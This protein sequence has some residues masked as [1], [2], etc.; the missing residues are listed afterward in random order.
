LIAGKA[1]GENPCLLRADSQTVA[2]AISIS[3]SER[4]NLF[5]A[6]DQY[7]SGILAGDW[8]AL[9]GQWSPLFQH[10]ISQD[11]F[12]KHMVSSK[13]DVTEY[14]VK[15]YVVE[16]N[17]ARLVVRIGDSEG[18]PRYGIALWG[19][20]QEGRWRCIDDGTQFIRTPRILF[21]EEDL[22]REMHEEP[23]DS[24]TVPSPDNDELSHEEN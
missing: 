11:E 2:Q 1:T 5:V 14:E 22:A 3:M 6:A 4:D 7:S 21:G 20:D 18:A 19:K 10:E 8:E 16:D 23:S 15:R 13:Y 24:K 17:V 12:V 9:Y